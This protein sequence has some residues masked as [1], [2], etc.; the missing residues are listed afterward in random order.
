MTFVGFK[1]GSI[2]GT[3]VRAVQPQS[4]AQKAG[5]QVDDVIVEF[6]GQPI[7]GPERLRWLASMAGVNS[8]VTV[9][10]QRRHQIMEV[11]ASLG[12]LP[13]SNSPFIEESEDPD[14]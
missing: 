6:Q 8:R 3:I 12:E 9:K 7:T 4:G 1:L 14:E 5:F 2:T 11:A 10:I 13:A